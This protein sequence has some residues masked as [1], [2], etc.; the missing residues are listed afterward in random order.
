[1]RRLFAAFVLSA[2]ILAALP[3]VAG[4]ADSYV[5]QVPLLPLPDVA[6]PDLDAVLAEYWPAYWRA[7][8]AEGF[9]RDDVR[10]G[11][12]DLDGD[13]AAELM[14]MIAAASWEGDKGRPL[15]VAVW[16]KKAWQPVA[17]SWGDS[18]TVFATREVRDGWR[19]IDTGREL[20]RWDGKA[21]GAE[22][23]PQ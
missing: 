22:P 1:M 3:A 9:G 10:A 15:V 7:A 6:Q 21:Y 12:I 16:R 17:W 18:D 4:E 23:K 19:T 13:G 2:V 8:G 11:R 14:L 20:L 5:A